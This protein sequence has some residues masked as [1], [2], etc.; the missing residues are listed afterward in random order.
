MSGNTRCYSHNSNYNQIVTLIKNYKNDDEYKKQLILQ[1]INKA[2]EEYKQYSHSL[3]LYTSYILY[4]WAMKAFWEKKYYYFIEIV[5][6]LYR[7]LPFVAIHTIEQCL[8]ETYLQHTLKNEYEIKRFFQSLPVVKLFQNYYR[9]YIGTKLYDV[10]KDTVKW[11]RNKSQQCVRKYMFRNT[12]I[13]T[14][15][16]SIKHPIYIPDLMMEEYPHIYIELNG[17]HY[18]YKIDKNKMLFPS[19]QNFITK[20]FNI[21]VHST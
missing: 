20:I 16:Q 14:L 13:E 7:Q 5:E 10:V 12:F 3:K 11:A 6:Y 4:V 21:I 17:I 2:K 18:E 15:I 1:Y 19:T 8:L 9:R